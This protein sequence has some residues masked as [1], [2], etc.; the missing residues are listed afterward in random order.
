MSR[1]ARQSGA[2]LL[3]ALVVTVAVMLLAASAAQTALNAEK[4]ARNERDRHLAFQ[5]A[6]AALADAER[7]IAGGFDPASARAALFASGDAGGFAEG[8]GRT[9]GSVGFGLCK[10][11][12]AGAPPAWQAADLGAAV[13]YGA[14]TGATLPGRPPRYIIELIP[15]PAPATRH[16]YRITAI[17]Y[18]MRAGTQVVLQ[19]FY[20][21]TGAAHL[22]VS[23]REVA[24]WQELHDAAT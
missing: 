2:A 9:A 22:R 4:S 13:P 7:D 5:S 18:G 19:S 3:A 10:C 24:N 21:K 17:G 8:C 15:E 1:F 20:R 11:A 14:F 23:W 12:A 16:L 6:E